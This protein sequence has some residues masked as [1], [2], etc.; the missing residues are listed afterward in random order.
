[1]LLRPQPLLNRSYDEILEVSDLTFDLGAVERAYER[2][3]HTTIDEEEFSIEGELLGM[4]PIGRRFE[5]KRKDDGKIISGKVGL[6]FSQD[7]LDRV[8]KEQLTGLPRRGFFQRREIKKLGRVR[9][10][11]VLTRLEDISA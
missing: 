10:V 2:A 4:I 8:S 11:Y 1:M 3:E 7:Y 5:F 6:L 9:E